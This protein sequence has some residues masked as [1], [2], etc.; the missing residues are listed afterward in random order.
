MPDVTTFNCTTSVIEE[1]AVNVTCIP[2]PE[3]QFVELLCAIDCE[4]LWPC[5]EDR[6]NGRYRGVCEI[7][8][9]LY[10]YYVIFTS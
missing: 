2:P 5:Q 10:A 1:T 4:T 9:N 3:L 8:E 6:L 7:M